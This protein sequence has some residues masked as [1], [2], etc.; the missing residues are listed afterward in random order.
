MQLVTPQ[1]WILALFSN[2]YMFLQ[3]KGSIYLF[4]MFLYQFFYTI[5]PGYLSVWLNTAVTR[6]TVS[7]MSMTTGT[8]HLFTC[9]VFHSA[10]AKR[11]KERKKSTEIIAPRL[12]PLPFLIHYCSEKGSYF[13]IQYTDSY[14]QVHTSSFTTYT[15]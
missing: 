6:D 3:R 5:H 11:K 10:T 7:A 4:K 1:H 8:D 9:A 13:H 2:L 15:D 12:V 14:V